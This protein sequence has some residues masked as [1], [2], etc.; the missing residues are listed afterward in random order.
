MTDN[1]LNADSLRDDEHKSTQKD[2]PKVPTSKDQIKYPELPKKKD[3]IK[4]R[5]GKHEPIKAVILKDS[6]NE[7][8]SDS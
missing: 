5:K 1:D 3:I 6:D 4:K 8:T 2:P 7:T